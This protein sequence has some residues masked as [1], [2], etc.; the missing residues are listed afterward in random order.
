MDESK[1]WIR[2]LVITLVVMALTAVITHVIY[3]ANPMKSDPSTSHYFIDINPNITYAVPANG[4][5]EVL[6]EGVNGTAIVSTNEIIYNGSGLPITGEVP[7]V[8]K[9]INYYVIALYWL[10]SGYEVVN[11]HAQAR[12][13]P[14]V[15]YVE[16]SGE[17][18]SVILSRG[19][20]YLYSWVRT[21]VGLKPLGEYSVSTVMVIIKAPNGELVS[22][23]YVCA[24]PVL[25]PPALMYIHM[26]RCVPVSNGVAYLRLPT[27]PY[28]ITYTKP[29]FLG[30]STVISV[31][32]KTIN[33]YGYSLNVTVTEEIVYEVSPSIIIVH[34]STIAVPGNGTIE[35]TVSVTPIPIHLPILP[36][37][38]INGAL[39]NTS[40]YNGYYYY[41]TNIPIAPPTTVMGTNTTPRNA[42]FA[43]VPP[44]STRSFITSNYLLLAA[45]VVLAVIVGITMS[46]IVTKIIYR[47]SN[48]LMGDGKE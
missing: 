27:I 12:W 42:L 25:P 10:Q 44:N 7:R 28:V 29:E 21:N 40:N 8:V 47:S 37:Y 41:P 11:G 43:P 46:I 35:I 48:Q 19:P 13:T 22:G 3:A 23:G 2:I 1:A 18:L 38:Y 14:E 34:G 24:N 33:V 45:M 17:E 6:I 30:N 26:L 16:I 39:T 20:Q 31:F 15:G 5:L 4:T 36:I 9:S 32:N